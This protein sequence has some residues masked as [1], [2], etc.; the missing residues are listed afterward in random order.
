MPMLVRQLE[1]ISLCHSLDQ[2]VIC[3]SVDDSDDPLARVVADAGYPVVRGSLSD[4]L[5]RFMS[6]VNEYQPD[7]LVRLT[8]DCPLASPTVIDA[9][10]ESFHASTADYLSNT[11]SPTYP[12]GLDVEV[13]T[14]SCLAQV[15]AVSSDPHEREHVTLGVYR[16]PENFEI[17]NYA[18][19][20]GRDHSSLRW[21]VDT[22]EDLDFVRR[23]YE[24]FSD[25]IP[26]FEYDDVLQL[27]ATDPEFDERGT[28]QRRNAAL[29]GLDT[30]VMQHL[31]GNGA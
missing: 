1:R 20:Q 27:L 29:D 12:D 22:R 5:D 10:V 28:P 18:D 15:A 17:R 31:P 13:V 2:I 14:S 16:R 24:H 9:V 30:G 7:V 23:V 8:G 4:V 25:S 11:M 6:V 3:T 26:T 21:T 19:P